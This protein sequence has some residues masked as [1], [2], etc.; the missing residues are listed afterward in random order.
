MADNFILKK[1]ESKNTAQRIK[2]LLF[3][4]RIVLREILRRVS[5]YITNDR[6]YLKLVWWCEQRCYLNLN[7]PTSFQEK[8]QWLKLFNRKPVHTPDFI[9]ASPKLLFVVN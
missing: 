5:K 6:L 3:H 9:N 4:P 7:N 1:R 8:L 2:R